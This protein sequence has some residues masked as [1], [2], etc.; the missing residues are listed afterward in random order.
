MKR[1][2]MIY[3]VS[4]ILLL[5]I[6]LPGCKGPD[7]TEPTQSLL[8]HKNDKY[9]QY[10]VSKLGFNSDMIKDNGEYF[11]IER[12]IRIEKKYL[13]QILSR[14]NK[15]QQ[16]ASSDF[17]VSINNVG[18]ITYKIDASVS[19]WSS[20]I[21]SAANNWSQIS[22]CKINL[23][24]ND[25]NPNITF[26]NS[27]LS[28][29]TCAV[30]SFPENGY[31]GST[32]YI[33]LNQ[34]L[35]LNDNEKIFLLVHE[36]GHALG[37]R[38]TN[39]QSLGETGGAYLIPRTP[40]TDDGSVMNGNTCGYSWIGFSSYDTEAA[41]VLYPVTLSQPSV[42]SMSHYTSY[43]RYGFSWVYLKADAPDP[44]AYVEVWRSI[45]G[46]SFSF[47]GYMELNTYT[48]IEEAQW[49]NTYTYKIRGVN[50]NKDYQSAFSS[51]YYQI[52]VTQ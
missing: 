46:G 11:L 48:Q 4:I 28:Y 12:D 37:F 34:D 5:I 2:I 23:V 15:T 40:Q 29:G 26:V 45:N 39:W 19:S 7:Q 38:H 8:T 32:I 31:P 20:V 24:R 25:I 16:W 18:S 35:S 21:Q 33:D 17:L 22:N 14:L 42:S 36:L 52:Y 44:A 50:F 1:L 10:L 3:G 27:S 47:I 6:L 51:Q 41:R 13:D 9:I 49:Y 43:S 30:S